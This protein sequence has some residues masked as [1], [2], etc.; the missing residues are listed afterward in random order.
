MAT[1]FGAFVLHADN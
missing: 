1:Y